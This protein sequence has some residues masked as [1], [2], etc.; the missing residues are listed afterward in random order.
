VLIIEHN[1]NVIAE[2]CDP[3]YV[4]NEGEIIA[5]GDFDTVRADPRVLE[6]YFGQRR[7]AASAAS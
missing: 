4:L 7:C 3:V 2:L 1:M 6:A 5:Q